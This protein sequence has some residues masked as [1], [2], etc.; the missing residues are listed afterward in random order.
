M[1]FNCSSVASY[2]MFPT[3]TERSD[4]SIAGSLTAKLDMIPVVHTADSGS[5][6]ASVL[7]RPALPLSNGSGS[8]DP[9]RNLTNSLESFRLPESHDSFPISLSADF[10]WSPNSPTTTGS[11]RDDHSKDGHI[12]F[13]KVFTPVSQAGVQW[14]SLDSLQPP[15]SG[16]K[17]SKESW[18]QTKSHSVIQLECSDV[19]LVYCNLHLPG[20]SNSASVSKI[21]G[22]TGAYHHTWLIFYF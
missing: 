12:D 4:R 13:T 3:N 6:E 20:S 18:A 17:D 9:G 5:F 11:V 21:A 1:S 7:L 19:I 10:L 16:L 8:Q 2:G 15:P 22:T 14:Y